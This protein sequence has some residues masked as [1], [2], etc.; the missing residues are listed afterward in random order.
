MHGEIIS[1]ALRVDQV[2]EFISVPCRHGATQ[3]SRSQCCK[4]NSRCSVCPVETEED[5]SDQPRGVS[6]VV[7]V[8]SRGS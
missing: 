1:A 8:A 2:V 5:V 3:V 4:D 6:A 7:F